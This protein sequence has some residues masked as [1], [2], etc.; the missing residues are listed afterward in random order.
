MQKIY[1]KGEIKPESVIQFLNQID[2]CQVECEII[3]DSVGGSVQAG[4]EI[5]DLILAKQKEGIQIH[6]TIDGLC[7]SIATIIALSVP[8]ENRKMTANSMYMIHLAF[9]DSITCDADCYRFVADELDAINLRMSKI[10]SAQTGLPQST[11]LDLMKSESWFDSEQSLKLGFVSE[12]LASAK[13]QTQTKKAVAYL[14]EKNTMELNEKFSKMEEAI[15]A[16][17]KQVTLV[18]MKP[19]K[20]KDGEEVFI[21]MSPED[22][23]MQGKK[24]MD[25]D[26]E[27]LKAGQYETEDGVKMV[28]GED[29]V[30]KEVIIVEKDE[31]ETVAE[32]DTEEELV[33]A[34]LSAK[35]DFALNEITKLAKLVASGKAKPEVI[36]PKI[37]KKKSIMHP[38]QKIAERF[39]ARINSKYPDYF[40]GAS[41][42]EDSFNY[43]YDGQLST[44]LIYKPTVSVPDIT[45]VFT[46]RQGVRSKQ[47]LLLAGFLSDKIIKTYQGCKGMELTSTEQA[48]IFNRTLEVTQLEVLLEQCADT[49]DETI[50]EEWKNLGVTSE[51]IEGT[52]F[53]TILLKLLIDAMGRGLFR[54]FSWGDTTA[55]SA[56]YNQ[57]DGLWTRLIASESVPSES[58][59]TAGAYCGVRVNDITALTQTAGQRAIDYLRTLWEA[60]SSILRQIPASEKA[61]FVTPNIIDNLATYLEERSGVD[62][63]IQYLENGK[64]SYTFRGVPI[65]EVTAWRDH[66][67]DPDNPYF[68]S[69]NTTILFTTPKNHIIGLSS[70]AAQR[71]T[72][73]W[74]SWDK[75]VNYVKALPEMGY[76]YAHCDLQV[77]SYGLV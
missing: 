13:A 53:Q 38:L 24:A 15:R 40:K 34:E 59:V 25:T 64:P 33:S 28:V 48:N 75:N 4:E 50:L 66:L 39:A 71:E 60:Q 20:M 31:D 70:A 57:L 56:D 18:A 12:I 65:V 55:L 44:D 69:I 41:V 27:P 74:Y 36:I 37:A 54:I 46:V 72:K 73:L 11:L 43:T 29:G 68:G 30:V 9:G 47:Q 67:E 8:Y 14:Q 26:G 52:Q 10:Y 35:L 1:I 3:I 32:M 51:S 76:N 16:L 77:F 22:E 62:V 49:F 42:V 21:G 19:V 7:A 61:F 58:P 23:D 6:T 45:R 5:R 63:A 2:Q 17:T